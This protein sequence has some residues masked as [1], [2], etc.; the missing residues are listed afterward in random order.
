MGSA[1]PP[2]H[3]AFPDLPHQS[4]ALSVSTTCSVC[5][6]INLALLS[7][8]WLWACECSWKAL[9]TIN[10]L[11]AWHPIHPKLTLTSTYGK[12]GG[13]GAF[14][15]CSSGFQ[16]LVSVGIPGGLMEE[17]AGPRPRVPIL[18]PGKDL[19]IP[20]LTSSLVMLMVRAGGHTLRTT[21]Q[22]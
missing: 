21:S 12:W 16:T 17:A 15:H 4:N 2:P 7:H 6:S 9:V 19:G 11:I 22:H 20:L 13:G 3:E 18:R 1:Q 14:R 10:E 5:P 8:S